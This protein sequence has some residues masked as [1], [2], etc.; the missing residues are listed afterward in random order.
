MDHP[1]FA[2]HSWNIFRAFL[3]LL[4]GLAGQAQIIDPSAPQDRYYMR[5]ARVT[6][7]WEMKDFRDVFYADKYNTYFNFLSCRGAILFYK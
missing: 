2:F 4:T 3:F 6:N 7:F 5:K 1:K